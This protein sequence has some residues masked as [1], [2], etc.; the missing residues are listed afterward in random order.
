MRL[1]DFEAAKEVRGGDE[2]EE[3]IRK[4]VNLV[5]KWMGER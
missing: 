3:E 5:N 1:I 4:V 2:E